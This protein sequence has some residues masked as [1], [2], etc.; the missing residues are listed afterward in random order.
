MGLSLVFRD[1][2]L[3]L[4]LE[5]RVEGSFKGTFARHC[6]GLLGFCTGFMARIPSNLGIKKGCLFELWTKGPF[7]SAM[8]Q[9]LEGSYRALLGL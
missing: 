8:A 2:S 9:C 1:L 5:F 6:E 4:R 3:G 7:L